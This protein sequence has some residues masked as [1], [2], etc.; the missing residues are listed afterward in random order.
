[1]RQSTLRNK[2]GLAECGCRVL[3]KQ[4]AEWYSAGIHKLILRYNNWRNELGEK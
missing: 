4:D 1:M 2:R 3:R